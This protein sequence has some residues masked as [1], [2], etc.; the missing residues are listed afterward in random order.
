VAGPYGVGF[1]VVQH[2]DRARVYKQHIDLTSGTTA[3]GERARPVQTLIWYPAKKTSG[4]P[5]HYGDYVRLAATETEF[6]RSPA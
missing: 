2:Y 5:L 1:R 6:A 3:T 4:Q